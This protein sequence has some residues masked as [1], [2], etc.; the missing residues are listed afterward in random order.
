MSLKSAWRLDVLDSVLATCL[1]DA[2]CLIFNPRAEAKAKRQVMTKPPTASLDDLSAK[3]QAVCYK[4]IEIED[5]ID[6]L[7]NATVVD[8]KAVKDS[9]Q[10]VLDQLDRYREL[11]ADV[12]ARAVQIIKMN[13]D[14]ATAYVRLAELI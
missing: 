6:D 4:I 7:K 13:V 2:S 10:L 12:L 3:L 1:A 14:D 5:E 9:E 11:Q 8:M